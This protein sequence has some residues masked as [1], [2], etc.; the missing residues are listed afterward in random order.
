[1]D[2]SKRIA[3]E[4]IGINVDEALERFSNIEDLFDSFLVKFLNYSEYN[5]LKEALENEQFEEAFKACHTMKGVVG[6]LSIIPLYKIV[7]EETE[8]LRNG[9]DVAGAV[10]LFPRLSAEYKRVCDLIRKVYNP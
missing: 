9:T 3:L 5:D 4:E 8:L 10:E 2:S 7:F 1:M 6:N